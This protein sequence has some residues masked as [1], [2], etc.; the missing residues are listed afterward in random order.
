VTYEG[1]NHVVVCAHHDDLHR[2]ITNLVDNAVRHGAKTVV[3]LVVDSAGVTVMIEDD[4]PGIRDADKETMFQPFARGDTARGMSE[5]YGFGLGLSIARTE[6]E[7]HGGTLELCDR[8]PTGLIATI[9]LPL[10]VTDA[11]A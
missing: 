4:G 10:A 2:A 1:P 11:V 7:A 3:H 8:T 9:R 6:I 5:G